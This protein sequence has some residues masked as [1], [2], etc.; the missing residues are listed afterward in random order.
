MPRLSDLIAESAA[1][2]RALAAMARELEL[3]QR[4]ARLAL[5]FISETR[6]SSP[7]GDHAKPKTYKATF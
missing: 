4:E 3:A 1:A 5:E 6:H 7:G 2:S